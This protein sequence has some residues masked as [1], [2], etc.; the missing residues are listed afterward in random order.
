[1]KVRILQ[2]SICYS[3]AHRLQNSVYR[4]TPSPKPMLT[5][6]IM[7]GFFCPRICAPSLD[8]GGDVGPLWQTKSMQPYKGLP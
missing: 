4:N 8:P 2:K 7:D 5:I 1:M 6:R 3:T